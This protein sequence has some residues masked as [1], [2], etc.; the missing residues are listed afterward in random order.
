L[1]T[2]RAAIVEAE[3]ALPPQLAAHFSAHDAAWAKVEHE[4]VMTYLPD[5]AAALSYAEHT[6]RDLRKESG[7]KDDPALMMIVKDHSQ[8]VLSLPFFPGC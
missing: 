5:V 4:K 8:T 6:I 3:S 1:R 7:Y 2:S